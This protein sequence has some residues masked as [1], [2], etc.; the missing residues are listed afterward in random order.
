VS[1]TGMLVLGNE[2]WNLSTGE[3]SPIT[4]DENHSVNNI[5]VS[6]NGQWMAYEQ[7]DSLVIAT[8]RGIVK[9]HP[10]DPDWS[11]YRWL[12]NNRLGIDQSPQPY[13]STIVLNPFTGEIERELTIE[14]PSIFIERVRV[15]DAGEGTSVH[16]RV[17]VY[18]DPTLTRV[19]YF[20]V[21][22]S[23]GTVLKELE[24]GEYLA[25]LP[26]ILNVTSG[27]ISELSYPVWLPNGQAFLTEAGVGEYTPDN[28]ELY[29]VTRDGQITRLTY[30]T[31]AF[32]QVRVQR[33]S[34]SP[35]G[36]YIAFWLW[37]NV[38]EEHRLA[39]LDMTTG[40]VVDTCIAGG[41]LSAAPP[42]AVI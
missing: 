7:G 35:D 37:T 3:K 6:P 31:E 13:T 29:S 8:V 32:E 23:G 5:H 42:G 41:T 24:T 38:H 27:G 40:M 39:V 11:T 4:G 14:D 18:Y 15:I 2:W 26:N 21:G 1:V 17:H 28:R 25:Q 33:Y 30:F 12:G 19:I 34:R 16:S 9:V 20:R 10:L 36:R 22:A